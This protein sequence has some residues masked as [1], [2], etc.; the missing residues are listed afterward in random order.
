MT[1]VLQLLLRQDDEREASKRHPLASL[2]PREREVLSYLAEGLGR[3]EV[4]ERMHLSANT[5]RSH[6]QNLMGKLKVHSTLEAV[7]IARQAHP[8]DPLPAP[9]PRS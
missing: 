8:G 2:T 7:A 9:P 6:L 5:V 4:S 1:Q 3:R